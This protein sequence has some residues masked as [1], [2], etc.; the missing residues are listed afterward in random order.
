R[1]RLSSL[2]TYA[3]YPSPLTCVRLALVSQAY[4]FN[5]NLDLSS[6]YI[7]AG[8]RCSHRSVRLIERNRALELRRS[9][10]RRHK[11]HDD[12]GLDAQLSAPALHLPTPRAIGRVE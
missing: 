8:R 4:L 12:A 9:R 6:G 3:I 5:G 10:P 2:I 11:A 1:S 7:S